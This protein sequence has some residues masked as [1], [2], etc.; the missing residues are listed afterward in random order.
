M[1]KAQNDLGLDAALDWFGASTKMTV[2]SAQPTTYAEATSD[3]MLAE[4]VIDSG[5][6]AKADGDTSGR[7]VTVAQ[8]ADVTVTN[9]GD[10]THVALVSTA[11]SV[12]RYVT[13]CDTVTLTAES[14]VTF[15][16]WDIE[17]ADAA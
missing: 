9:T 10:A 16:A 15:P 2:C 14:T 8:Q 4:I 1:G 13:T 17:I 3:Y 5:D 11:D 7:K 12:L 6:F